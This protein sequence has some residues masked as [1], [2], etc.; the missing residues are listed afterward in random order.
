MVNGDLADG[1]TV[2]VD[3][4]DGELHVGARERVSLAA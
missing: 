1:G 2:R 4:R 3:A